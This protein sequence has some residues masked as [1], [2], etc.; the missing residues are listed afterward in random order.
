LPLVKAFVTSTGIVFVIFGLVVFVRVGFK[1]ILTGFSVVGE[2]VSVV[3]GV[4]VKVFTGFDVTLTGFS[5]DNVVVGLFV[6]VGDEV[7]TGLE[8]IVGLLLT[9]TF[10]GC[11]EGNVIDGRFTPP[12]NCGISQPLINI[13]ENTTIVIAKILILYCIFNT[14]LIF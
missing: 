6:S 10:I 13:K 11:G 4:L 3:V 5:V 8:V 2:F 14:S 12:G 9:V 7:T 1:T